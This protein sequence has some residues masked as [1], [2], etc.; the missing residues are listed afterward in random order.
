MT[1]SYYQA[2]ERWRTRA[3]EWVLYALAWSFRWATWWVPVWRL[4]GAVAPLGGWLAL[5]IPGFRRRAIENLARV[6][7][8]LPAARHRAIARSAGAQ[9]ARLMVEYARL[10][11]WAREV[12]I[13]A[14]GTDHLAKARA[15]G[16]GIV[17]VSAHYGNWEAARLA[18]K[19]AGCETGIIYRA[20]NNRYLDRFTLGLIPLAGEPVLQKGRQGMRRLVAHVSRGGAVM[21]LVDQRNSGAPFVDFLGHPAETV[22]AAAD[23]A[24]RTGAALIPARAVRNV[25]GRRFDVRFE[26]P[27]KA[28]DAE[29]AMAAVNAR[30]GAWVT[31]HPE[32]WFWF[33]RRWRSTIRSR[34]R[35]DR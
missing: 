12:E 34:S 22:T 25:A 33:H 14:E 5:A 18:A 24:L 4:S 2:R 1:E 17:M 32:Q 23:L 10:D 9:F 30:L 16:R 13:R 15:A 3:V 7:P 29:T 19:R 21:I 27:V 8:D 6:W 20:F 11:K 35:P 26:E 31:D 28:P